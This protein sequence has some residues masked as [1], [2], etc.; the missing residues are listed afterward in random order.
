M[1]TATKRKKKPLKTGIRSGF[2]A[3]GNMEGQWK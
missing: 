1:K 2:G 3:T